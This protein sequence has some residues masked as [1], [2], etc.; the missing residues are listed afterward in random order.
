MEKVLH[1]PNV[2][3]TPAVHVSKLVDPLL[4]IN[5]MLKSASQST[6]YPLIQHK[7]YDKAKQGYGYIYI[8]TL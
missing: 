1:F 5:E 6:E 2:N 4:S 7:Q 8:L 3:I